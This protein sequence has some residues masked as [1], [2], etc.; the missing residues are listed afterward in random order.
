MKASETTFQPIIEGTKQ[1]VVPLFQRPYSW[2]KKEWDVL[3]DDLV[4]LCENNEPKSHFIGSI[5]TMP[6]ISVPQGVSKYLLID[7]QQR[8]TTIFILLIVLRDLAKT[9]EAGGQLADEIQVTM[10]VNQF[11]KDDDFFKLLPTQVD[12]DNFK[13]LIKGEHQKSNNPLNDCYTYFERKIKQTGLEIETLAKVIT[14]RLSSVGIVLDFDDN[15]HLVFESLNAKGRNLTQADLIRNYFFMR[16]HVDDQ[17]KYHLKY[18]DPMQSAL[19]DELTEFVRHYLMKDGSFVKQNEIYFT[20]KDRIGQS[21][22][23]QALR[24]MSSYSV[25]YKKIIDPVSETNTN[26]RSY[27]FR[28]NRLEVTTA[29]PFLLNCYR[30]YEDGRLSQNDFLETIKLIENF[31]I[32]R[33]VCNI[34]TNQL[35]KIFPSLYSQIIIRNSSSFVDGVRQNLQ[36]RDYPKDTE[37][38]QRL[39]DAK[40]YGA[41]ERLAKTKF[42][43][44]TLEIAHAHKESTVFE[45]LTVE[46]VMPQT[47]TESWKQHLGEDWQADHEL[48]LNVLGNLTLTAYNSELSNAPFLMKKQY[49]IKSHLE[50]NKYFEQFI[51]WRKENIE[52][53]SNYLAVKALKVW[54]YFG[55]ESVQATTSSEVTG[56]IPK[57]VTILGTKLAVSS[58]RDVLTA[59]LSTLSELEPELF[60]NLAL[61]YPRFIGKDNARFVK[62]RQLNSGH[63]IE[64][65]LSAQNIY[66]FCVQAI[67]T[68]GLSVEDWVVE[69]L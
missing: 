4:W 43:L 36:S 34:P 56:K 45:N 21:D 25:Y 60:E 37:F 27:L 58:W 2:T 22:A 49:L 26:I 10:L 5:V 7:G 11:K 16:I 30:D 40:L 32:R 54:S 44:E 52:A 46:H 51:A 31:I 64:I 14:T 19:G 1:Y 66:R 62:S 67:E 33:F 57:S 3:W 8:L 28:L 9:S 50:L 47:I 13:N 68:V 12:R 69:T 55:D 61:E 63:F 35:N 29:Y 18:W 39:V 38:R 59:T 65:N 53:R 41:G 15:P 6:T 42:I 24:D 23:V 20:L 48:Y 17:E